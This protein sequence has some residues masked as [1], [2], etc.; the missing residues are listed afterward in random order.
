MTEGVEAKLAE[1]GLSLPRRPTPIASFIPY[2]VVHGLAYLSGQTCERD[3]QLPWTGQASV[4]FDLEAGQ[5][6]A[7]ACAL[8][9]L[10]ALREAC[11]GDWARVVRCIRVGGFVQ[12]PAGYPDV[13]RIIDGASTLFI[14]LFGEAG[15]HART[16]IG[17]ATLPRNA[18]VEVEAIFEI[19]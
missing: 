15:R 3:G 17:V 4:D 7:E 14:V 10:A 19:R 5:K 2:R 6:A 8:N 11:D 12:A 16:A 9:L 13:P 18:A 1:L